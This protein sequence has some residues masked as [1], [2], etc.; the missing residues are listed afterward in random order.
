MTDL[1]ATS[2]TDAA[3]ALDQAKR[4]VVKVGSSL[5]A[6]LDQ[7]AP[8]LN[9]D[10]L[11]TNVRDVQQ[12]SGEVCLVSSGAVAM[13]ADLKIDFGEDLSAKQALSAIGQI[14]LM[15]RWQAALGAHGLTPAQVLLTPDITARR[16]RYLNARAT[17]RTLMTRQVIPIINEND[18]VAT[19]EIRYGDNDRLAAMT[20][21]LVGADV[22]ILLTDTDGLY[23]DNPFTHPDADH[24]SHI[25][26][27]ALT[28][29]DRQQ[30]GS[31]SG[32]GTGGMASK[33][34]AARLASAWGINVVIASGLT[35]HPAGPLGAI[36]TKA[37]RATLIP[38]S[39]Q[40]VSA[41]RR[42]LEGLMPSTAN[43]DQGST[44]TGQLTVDTGAAAALRAGKSLL[45]VGVTHIDTPFGDGDVVVVRE[46]GRQIGY[47]LARLPSEGLAQRAQTLVIHRDDFVVE[48]E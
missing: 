31:T 11:C 15:N 17:L 19:D 10:A 1:S 46:A 44:N 35:T 21:G 24:I 48:D 34:D 14:G 12:R 27:S 25:L 38:A 43:I 8:A 33:L 20:A 32:V 45:A 13:G 40:P 41:R 30:L 9:L 26:P 7:K 18:A 4:W 28:Q 47:G 16:R 2:P 36:L 6:P 23:T 42:W 29:W 37:A 39:D 22:L 3:A 5:L